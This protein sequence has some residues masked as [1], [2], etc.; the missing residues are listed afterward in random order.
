[1]RP[2]LG[3][4]LAA[5]FWAVRSCWYAAHGEPELAGLEA[6]LALIAAT[7]AAVLWRRGMRRP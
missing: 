7:T 6:C 5:L 2:G 3:F 4:A 1:M